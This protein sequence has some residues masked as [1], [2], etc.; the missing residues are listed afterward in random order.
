VR[1]VLAGAAS[2]L[3][4]AQAHAMDAAAASTR[5]RRRLGIP[6]RAVTLP[7]T[8]CAAWAFHPP[9]PNEREHLDTGAPI[10]FTSVRRQNLLQEAGNEETASADAARMSRRVRIVG[11]RSGP[12]HGASWLGGR[13]T[14]RA[15]AVAGPRDPPRR[16]SRDRDSRNPLGGCGSP[17]SRLAAVDRKAGPS[18]NA[19][20]APCTTPNGGIVRDERRCRLDLRRACPKDAAAEPAGDGGARQ[21]RGRGDREGC[22]AEG[23]RH[24][25][26]GRACEEQHQPGKSLQRRHQPAGGHSAASRTSSQRWLPPPPGG[27]S[28]PDSTTDLSTITRVRRWPGRTWHPAK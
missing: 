1:A 14:C 5:R 8:P 12:R 4:P 25:R 7:S 9:Y 2:P 20:A 19:G 16:C 23:Q 15:I 28:G 10:S 26:R 3:A 27:C 6:T 13:A 21:T 17:R 24:R 22:G 18:E 11:R